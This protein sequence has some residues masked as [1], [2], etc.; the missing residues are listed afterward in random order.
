V[1]KLPTLEET[2]IALKWLLNHGVKIDYET[3]FRY[4]EKIVELYDKQKNQFEDRMRVVEESMSA[5]ERNG[6]IADAIELLTQAGLLVDKKIADASKDKDDAIET[7]IDSVVEKGGTVFQ[8]VNL[9]AQVP[10]QDPNFIDKIDNSITQDVIKQVEKD[11]TPS[12]AS[13]KAIRDELDE[14]LGILAAKLNQTELKYCQAYARHRKRGV[15]AREAGSRHKRPE[16]AAAQIMKNPDVVEYINLMTQKTADIAVLKASEV[17]TMFRD[18]YEKSLE[19]G[20][21][22]EANV[23]ARHLAEICGAIGKSTTDNALT[24]GAKAKKEQ[25]AA[26]KADKTSREERIDQLLKDIQTPPQAA[27]G[28]KQ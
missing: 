24:Q 21:F 5:K 11:M 10:N 16:V 15:A 12:T 17:I 19:E 1:A 25:E 8:N 7:L 27:Q 9:A 14:Q 3:V 4:P 2:G 13:E 26:Q 6:K 22:K 20:A 18:I 28:S 23:A